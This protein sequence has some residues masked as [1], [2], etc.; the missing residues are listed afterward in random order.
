MAKRLLHKVSEAYLAHVIDI[1]TTY[2]TL[3]N[4]LVVREFFNVFL[5]DLP[6]LLLDKELEFYIDLLPRI[7]PISIPL[8]RM[9]PTKLKELKT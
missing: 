6:R 1:S 8:Y 3:E 4:V 2:V 5:E 7:A 9:T